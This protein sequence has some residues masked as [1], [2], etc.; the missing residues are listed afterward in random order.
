[1]TDSLIDDAYLDAR[2]VYDIFNWGLD[3]LGLSPGYEKYGF[4]GID[5]K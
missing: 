3:C 4:G 2:P 5:Y 1:M